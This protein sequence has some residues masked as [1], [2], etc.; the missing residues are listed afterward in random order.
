MNKLK[1]IF[2]TL[3][4]AVLFVACE[5]VENSYTMDGYMLDIYT[6]KSNSTLSQELSDTVLSVKNIGDFELQAG[7]RVCLYLYY[8]YDLYNIKNNQLKI[9]NMVAKIPTLSISEREDVNAIDYDLLLG[10]NNYLLYKKDGKSYFLTYPY[11]IWLWDNRLNVIA[12]FASKPENVD[13]VMSLRDVKN[14]TVNFNLLAKTTA[15]MD[16]VCTKLLSY[17]LKN[18]RTLLTDEEKD[19]L[20]RH[21]KLTFQIFMKNKNSKDSL[22]EQSWGVMNGKFVNPLF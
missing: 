9:D 6:V 1:G 13:F 5:P 21:Q 4:V 15:P 11:N 17:D 14:D 22:V 12:S 7:D 16:T 18:F 10:S 8:H 19:E 3:V 2:Y 20:R